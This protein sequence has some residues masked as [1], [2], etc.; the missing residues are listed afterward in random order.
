MAGFFRNVFKVLYDEDVKY[1]LVGG[2][3]VNLYGVVRATADIDIVVKL[4]KSNVLSL[5]KALEKLGYKPKAPVSIE[6][7]ADPENRRNWIE[8]KDMKVF[9]LSPPDRTLGEVNI[10]VREPFDFDAAYKNRT[11][12]DIGGVIVHIASIDDLIFLKEKAGRAQDIS[13]IEALKILKK[14]TEETDE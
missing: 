12:V 3:A 6:D 5:V 8:K 13:D 10:F 11:D 14:M 4:T 9:S 7:F 2:V 1:L